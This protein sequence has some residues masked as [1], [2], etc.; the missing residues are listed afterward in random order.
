[1]W[2]SQVLQLSRF[3]LQYVGLFRS[4]SFCA[5]TGTISLGDSIAGIGDGDNSSVSSIAGIGPYGSLDPSG[6]VD[7]AGEVQRQVAAFK[8]HMLAASQRSWDQMPSV[9]QNALQL[10]NSQSPGS[11]ATGFMQGS[12]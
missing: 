2:G 12:N 4:G 3:V 7:Q 8:Q 10:S 1:M 5:G 11:A 6:S 9:P